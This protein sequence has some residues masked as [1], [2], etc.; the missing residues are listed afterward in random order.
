MGLASGAAHDPLAALLMCA[1]APA[2]YT[3]VNGRVL[4]R[5]GQL[6]RIDLGP[7]VQRHNRLARPLVRGDA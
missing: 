5:E 2:A 6:T 4:V 1:P 3:V 7:L